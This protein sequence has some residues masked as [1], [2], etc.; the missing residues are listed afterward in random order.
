MAWEPWHF[1][2][3]YVLARYA[4][5]EAAWHLPPPPLT[6]GDLR[7]ARDGK[8]RILQAIYERL[9]VCS[10]QYDLEPPSI[11]EG[12]QEIRE[13]ARI[14]GP[15]HQATCLD[16]ALLF[17]GIALHF[18]LL[19]LLILTQGHALLAIWTAQFGRDV[20]NRDR[21]ELRPFDEGLLPATRESA[22]RRWI[23]EGELFALECTGVAFTGAHP[24]TEPELAK[25]CEPPRTHGLL[26]FEQAAAAGK[27]QLEL[28]R[29]PFIRALD[30]YDLVIARGRGSFPIERPPGINHRAPDFTASPAPT[31]SGHSVDLQ[32]QMLRER[33]ALR[34]E[35]YVAVMDKI[36]VSISP[37][38]GVRLQVEA[39]KLY[40]EMVKIEEELKRLG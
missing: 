6:I 32:R 4:N 24:D 28:Q 29:R 20:A 27:A 1:K 11:Q 25:S 35:E 36:S 7:R 30:L 3:F 37:A 10:I 12:T 38:D 33:L 8:S 23:A 18:D 16:L 9:M 5:R 39:D 31:R 40:A 13:P 21:E 34:E 19:P 26:T 15:P 14:I 17:G 2:D 22:L